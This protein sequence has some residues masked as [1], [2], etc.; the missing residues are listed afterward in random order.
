MAY[1]NSSKGKLRT[2]PTA[3]LRGLLQTSHCLLF[4]LSH[5]SAAFCLLT[6]AHLFT[7]FTRTLIPPISTYPLGLS[8]PGAKKLPDGSRKGPDPADMN[9][10]EVCQWCYFF[11]Q[12]PASLPF[13]QPA[14]SLPHS[15]CL[16]QD[17]SFSCF[18]QAAPLLGQP[19]CVSA[20]HAGPTARMAAIN[21]EANQD[22]SS[23]LVSYG[24]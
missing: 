19:D 18:L 14:L 20:A 7:D 11:G 1:S 12:Q 16:S 2:V 10:V 6:S 15:F 17:F 24:F 4:T 8:G 23:C 21:E 22:E 9:Q 3:Y 5:F 13:S